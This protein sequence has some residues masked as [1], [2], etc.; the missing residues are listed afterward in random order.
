[1]E[2]RALEGAMHTWKVTNGGGFRGTELGSFR[3]HLLT[4]M[5]PGSKF[6]AVWSD[7]ISFK[8]QLVSAGTGERNLTNSRTHLPL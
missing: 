2:T 1:M 4:A 5:E 8:F 7:S 3:R 6:D